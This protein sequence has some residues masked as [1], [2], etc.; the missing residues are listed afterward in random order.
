MHVSIHIFYLWVL[1]VAANVCAGH[2]AR[3]RGKIDGEHGEKIVAV[4]ETRVQ[5]L[6]HRLHWKLK[7]KKFL[8]NLIH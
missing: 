5:V 8:K 3:R 1:Q 4:A 2:D 6:L 7:S